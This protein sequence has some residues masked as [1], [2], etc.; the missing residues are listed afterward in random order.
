MKI[1]VFWDVKPCSLADISQLFRGTY[2][3]HLQE[4]RRLIP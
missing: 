4:E 2:C 3:L 1:T